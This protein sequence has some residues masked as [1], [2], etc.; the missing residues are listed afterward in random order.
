[1]SSVRR[2]LRRLTG[3]RSDDVPPAVGEVE[4]GDLRRVTPIARDFGYK[5]GPAVDR[6][7]IESFLSKTAPDVRGRVLEV[8]DNAYTTRF[9]G[10]R[11]TQSDVLF[12]DNGLP[13]ATIVGDLESGNG[14][15]P[16]AFDCAIITQTLLLIYDVHASVRTL[17][18]VLRPGGVA[19]VT[20]PGISQMARDEDDR[21]G[22]YWRFTT[23]GASRLFGD[24]FG[25]RA[26]SV[27][28]YG[29][30]LTATA[31]LY[32]MTASE[33]RPEEYDY[34]DPEFPLIITVRA[35]KE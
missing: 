32:G 12:P 2:I 1:M 23:R 25:E 33:L 15:P 34:N 9:G 26:T 5:R 28:S 19:L 3:S 13:S 6:Y 11:V 22:D 7:Y 29:N 24:V 35:V 21:W 18:R 17:H 31:L 27:Q 4:M 30:V 10:G 16:D 20:L 8:G 14:I